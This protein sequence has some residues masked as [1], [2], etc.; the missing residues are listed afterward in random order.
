MVWVWR[1]KP[2]EILDGKGMG[3]KQGEEGWMIKVIKW[4]T[5]NRKKKISLCFD[6]FL[7]DKTFKIKLNKINDF[8]AFS[9]F[10]ALVFWLKS[11]VNGSFNRNKRKV[12]KILIPK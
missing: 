11:T 7:C 12:T 4:A 6:F 2:C 1:S 9:M 8:V 5:K 10:T 3:R